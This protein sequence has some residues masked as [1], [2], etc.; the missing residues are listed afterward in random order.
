MIICPFGTKVEL[1]FSTT[2]DGINLTICKKQIFKSPLRTI[3]RY[4]SLLF[5]RRHKEIKKLHFIVNLNIFSMVTDSILSDIK[6]LSLAADYFDLKVRILI[7]KWQERIDLNNPPRHYWH[8][9]KDRINKTR[10]IFE[11]QD[12][13]AYGVILKFSFDSHF[14]NTLYR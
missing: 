6:F 9:I 1:T 11:E 8:I 7:N 3:I 5:Q 4:L 2:I 14:F 13:F 10:F 12:A